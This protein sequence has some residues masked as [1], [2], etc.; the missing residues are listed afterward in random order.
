MLNKYGYFDFR[1]VVFIIS[2]LF[3]GSIAAQEPVWHGF[4]SQ[5]LIQAKDSNF[6][7]DS[8]ELSTK[9]TELGING[10]YQLAPQLRIAGQVVYLNGGNRYPEG[11]RLDYLFLDWQLINR[12]DWQVNMHLGRYKNYHWL[13][14]ATRDVPH[15][16]P[17]IILPQSI[18]FD[19]FRDTAVGSD[20]AALLATTNGA[21]GEW[22]IN[23]SYGKSY[24][25]RKQTYN[26]FSNL[27]GGR[28]KQDFVHQFGVLWRP[29][30]AN[31]QWGINLLDSNFSYLQSAEDALTDGKATSQ[32][33]M[34]SFRYDSE[35]WD[36][37]TELMKE[38]VVFNNLLFEGFANTSVAEG[39][40]TQ[41]R[42]FVTPSITALFRLD[43]FDLN[44]KDR[45]GGQR[46]ADSFGQVPAYFGYMDKA[47]VGITWSFAESWRLQGEL[48]RVKG[49]GRLAPV[50][51]PNT[52]L[53][54]HEYWDI[55]AVQLMYWF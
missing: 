46:E 36:V 5:G 13:Y 54:D 52:Q 25:S 49:A 43:L 37:A 3:A 42:Y 7:N 35:Y 47:T 8:G 50:L 9:L 23:W 18:Y 26:F 39:G 15:T 2:C 55:V 29:A 40:Y 17:S 51:I 10:A 31:M 24:I 28:I 6:V 48:H 12:A 38:R 41:F 21:S 20:G 34:L 4:A 1:Q 27:A 45:S 19:S 16:R 11:S 22:D 30:M 14:S 53:N 44:N 33:L 32:R